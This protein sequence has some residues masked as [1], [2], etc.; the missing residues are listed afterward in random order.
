VAGGRPE[1]LTLA[2]CVAFAVSD[3]AIVA[4]IDGLQQTAAAAHRPLGRL[5]VGLLAML[6]TYV[7]CGGIATVGLVLAPSLRPATRDDWIA[8]ARYGATWLMGMAGLYTCFGIVGVIFGNILQSTRGML[9]IA[10]GAAVARAGWHGLETRVDR[11][12][13]TRRLLAAAL[14]TAAIALY[15]IDVA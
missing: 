12:T 14:M 6:V 13:L 7:V 1:R 2:A 8:G 4:L 9:S 15:V 3:L 11:R 10:I 5:H